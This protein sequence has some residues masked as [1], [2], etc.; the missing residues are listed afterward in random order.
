MVVYLANKQHNCQKSLH[1]QKF[2]IFQTCLNNN[3]EA[4]LVTF[5]SDCI[6]TATNSNKE[7]VLVTYP[8]DC[9][10][11]V[12]DTATNN[13]KEAVLVTFPS[14]CFASEKHQQYMYGSKSKVFIDNKQV[15]LAKCLLG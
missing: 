11:I 15:M 2:I 14:D 3:K 9:F 1:Q 12:K 5:P 8:S 7:A 10:A 4:V 13:N 6:D